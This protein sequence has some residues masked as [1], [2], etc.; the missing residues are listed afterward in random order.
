MTG[1][2]NLTLYL[3][4]PRGFC[5]GV[6]RALQMLDTTLVRPTY[7]LHE[8]VHNKQVVAAYRNKGFQFVE[9]VD[10][11]PAGATVI[12]SAHGAGQD[13][14]DALTQKGCEIMDATC[15]FVK[16]V[17]AAAKRL[18]QSGAAVIVIGKKG[19]AEVNGILGQINNGYVVSTVEDID[20][21]PDFDKVGCVMQTTLT[22]AKVDAIVSSLQNRYPD[23]IV[24]PKHTMCQ[25][26]TERQNAVREAA[27]ICDGILV[28]GDTHSSNSKELVNVAV[29]AGCPAYLVETPEDVDLLPLT[30]T[31]GITAS[32]SAPETIVEG[33]CRKLSD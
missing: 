12:I 14:F 1:H 22:A 32:A 19:H 16:K 8:I 9:T 5:F 6:C 11:V 21:L 15:P 24:P 31:I 7:V 29:S 28:V 26:T 25:A 10:E 3:I 13:I 2:K 27:Q 20:A 30:G 4:E 33:I 23:L 18:A 17:H